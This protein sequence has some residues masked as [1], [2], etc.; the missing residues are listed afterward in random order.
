MT[1]SEERKLQTK[2]IIEMLINKYNAYNIEDEMGGRISFYLDSKLDNTFQCEYHRS[3]HDISIYEN[4]KLSG[5][6]WSEGELNKAKEANKY[7]IMLNK[8]VETLISLNLNIQ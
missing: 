6:G 8:E 2:S 1:K 5:E 7:E 4:T 3:N